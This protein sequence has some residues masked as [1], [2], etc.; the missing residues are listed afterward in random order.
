MIARNYGKIINIC[1]LAGVH[2]LRAPVHYAT[3]KA[4]VK[5]FTMALSKEM[6]RYNIHVNSISPGLINEGVSAA[7]PEDLKAEFIKHCSLGRLGRAE[8]IAELAAF[9][10]SDRCSYLSGENIVVDGGV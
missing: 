7:V 5:G 9:V 4:A 6:A 10:A 3:S 2:L 8:E 1:S